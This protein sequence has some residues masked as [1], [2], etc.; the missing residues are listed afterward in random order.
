MGLDGSLWITL[1]TLAHDWYEWVFMVLF[2]HNDSFGLWWV[3]IG[4][5]WSWL[6]IVAPVTHAGYLWV[7]LGPDRSQWHMCLM[8][9]INGSWCITM[10]HVA[11]DE[12]QWVLLGP[13]GSH[14]ALWLMMAINVYQLVS[15]C[16]HGPDGSQWLLWLMMGIDVSL[17]VLMDH[18]SPLVWL[19]MCINGLWR[20]LIDHNGSFGSQWFPRA[21]EI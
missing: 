21:L 11:H 8:M 6:I 15:I 17:W 3:S 10:A 14:W 5:H 4:L 1:A 18:N 16:L 7:L 13:Y 12:Y 20:V 9:G 2:N 19:M